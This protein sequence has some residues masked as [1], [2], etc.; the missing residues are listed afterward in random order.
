LTN[1]GVTM[2]SIGAEYPKNRVR[3][4]HFFSQIS[5]KITGSQKKF[6]NEKTE[7]NKTN[8]Y[9]KLRKM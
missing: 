4:K 2:P 7:T 3:T 5:E 9:K 6:I 1:V 8:N